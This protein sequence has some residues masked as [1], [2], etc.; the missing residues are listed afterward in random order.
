[1]EDCKVQAF[2]CALAQ[3]MDASL[4]M[5]ALDLQ[6]L[7]SEYTHLPVG[8]LVDR[9]VKPFV[10]RR[11]TVTRVVEHRVCGLGYELKDLVPDYAHVERP[12]CHCC[13]GVHL[14][15]VIDVDALCLH[16]FRLAG[17]PAAESCAQS[18]WF[19]N[20]LRYVLST[21][22]V[23]ACPLASPTACPA[24]APPPES[25]LDHFMALWVR[26]GQPQRATFAFTTDPLD[27]VAALALPLRRFYEQELSFHRSSRPTLTRPTL[28][29]SNSIQVRNALR[30]LDASVRHLRVKGARASTTFTR[31]P[32]CLKSLRFLLPYAAEIAAT[33]LNSFA[34]AFAGARLNRNV[35]FCCLSR[36]PG[37]RTNFAAIAALQAAPPAISFC[38]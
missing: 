18:T 38:E 31:S 13:V 23:E 22:D 35:E 2:D 25:F 21:A 33:K 6:A 10:W 28:T 19:D 14:R 27:N 29:R 4:P 7:I 11:C 17:A 12:M 24:L 34:H 36:A 16:D 9:R 20:G 1:M 5:L 32:E 15:A 37:T 8:A 26:Y 3:L 30:A